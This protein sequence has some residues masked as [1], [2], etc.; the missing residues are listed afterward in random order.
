M[1]TKFKSETVTANLNYKELFEKFTNLN[2]LKD[3]LPKEVE[4]FE[5]S[6][7]NCTFKIEQLPKM[8]LQITEKHAFSKIKFE[9]NESQIPFNMYCFINANDENTTN[10]DLEINMEVNFMMKML[11]Q[12]PIDMFLTQFTE[13]IKKI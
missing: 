1:S 11:V 10:V 6:V 7:D 2:N 8:S 13:I 3:Y 12:K 5:S 9:S 4:E